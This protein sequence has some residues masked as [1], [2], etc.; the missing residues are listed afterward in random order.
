MLISLQNFEIVTFDGIFIYL[1]IDKWTANI[2]YDFVSVIIFVSTRH[3]HSMLIGKR[4]I[5]CA[6][7]VFI[8]TLCFT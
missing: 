8:L 4:S 7:L 2:E 6:N 3:D 1:F 5:D